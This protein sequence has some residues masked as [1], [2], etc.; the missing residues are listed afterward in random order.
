M[1]LS[2][3]QVREVTDHLLAGRKIAAVK[4]YREA[5]GVGLKEAKESVEAL[6]ASLREKHPDKFPAA[7][8]GCGAMIAI[9]LFATALAGVA[10][11]WLL[12]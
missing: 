3:Q 9:G 5:T 7:K 2:D 1:N 6:E 11:G 4:V 12:T 8:A 10:G